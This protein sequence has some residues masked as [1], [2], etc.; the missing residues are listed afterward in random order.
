M[1][2]KELV[3]F[4]KTIQQQMQRSI[5][6]LLLLISTTTFSQDYTGLW[7][8]EL[9]LK[10]S[11]LQVRFNMMKQTDSA[12]LGMMIF[13]EFGSFCDSTFMGETVHLKSP[14]RKI[15]FIGS[16]AN[17][18]NLMTG[19]FKYNDQSYNINVRRGD[20]PLYRPQ[21]PKR[22]YPY[23]SEDI[24]FENQKD[25]VQLAGTLTI[26][27]GD[28]KYPAAIIVSG[29]LPSGRNGGGYHHEPFNV[30]ADYLTRNGIAVLRYDDRGKNKSTGDF[31]K[32]TPYDFSKDIEAGIQ[33]LANRKEI[34]PNHIG[35]IGHSEGGVVAGISASEN[36][37]VDFIVLLDLRVLN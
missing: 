25:S 32:S 33:F 4:E 26:P 6:L 31:F 5:F 7:K 15:Q 14:D 10:D 24:I 3:T 11:T 34:D 28:G 29:S 9:E 12:C 1:G 13:P 2:T 16:L 23:I 37:D 35:I 27:K 30:I 36:K 20:K 8:G 19:S 21:T 17:D 22:P 18:L